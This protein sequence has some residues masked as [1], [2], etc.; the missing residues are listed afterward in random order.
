MSEELVFDPQKELSFEEYQKLAWSVALYK[1]RGKNLSY[2]TIGMAGECGEFADKVKKHLRDDEE[3]ELS[4]ERRLALIAELGDL[5]WYVAAACSELNVPME[6][7][8]RM[9]ID[10]LFRRKEKGTLQGSGD[11]R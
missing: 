3:G 2:V 11:H 10:K 4:A 6:E 7:V 5:L 8:A 9:N 1:N